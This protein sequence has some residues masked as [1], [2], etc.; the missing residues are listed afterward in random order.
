MPFGFVHSPKKG[1]FPCLY[2]YKLLVF[3]LFSINIAL[4]PLLEDTKYVWIHVGI[5]KK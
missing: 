1:N 3:V 2:G 4:C 5:I